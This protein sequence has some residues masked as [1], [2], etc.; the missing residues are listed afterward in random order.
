MSDGPQTF[1]EI[2]GRVPLRRIFKRFFERIFDVNTGHNHDGVNSKTLSPSANIE[3]DSITTAK[4]ADGAVTALKLNQDVAGDGIQLDYATNAIE[5]IVDNATIEID[6]TEGM[7]VKD[8]GIDTAQIADDAITE[9]KIL[10]G[11]VSAWKLDPDVAGAGV[12]LDEVLNA[13]NVLVDDSTI[14]IDSEENKLQ[15]PDAGIGTEQIAD[16]TITEDK[17]ADDAVTTDKILD[18]AVT[19]S[20]LSNGGALATLLAAGL[21]SVTQV[22]HDDDDPVPL[23]TSSDV[24][25][26]CLIVAIVDETPSETVSFSIEDEN[27]V[28]FLDIDKEAETGSV[29]VGAGVLDETTALQVT[30]VTGEEETPAGKITVFVIAVPEV[31]AGD[32]E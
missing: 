22:A 14:E 3:N 29:L 4:I 11:S 27:N 18:G 15:V 5:V 6:E 8:A 21:G 7:Q 2:Y 17:I 28:L 25:R 26:A 20:K 1:E 13:I 31:A 10:D 19:L 16:D 32:E 23:L 9:D 30:I 12:G 24:A